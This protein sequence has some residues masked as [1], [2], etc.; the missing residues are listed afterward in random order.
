MYILCISIYIDILVW[1]ALL[2]CPPSSILKCAM[3]LDPLSDRRSF[4]PL[5]LQELRE[6]RSDPEEG[7]RRFRRRGT[8][9]VGRLRRWN[10]EK[11]T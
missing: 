5:G 6:L 2:V 10:E 3:V 1:F 9:L 8:R 11:S 7:A 4:A